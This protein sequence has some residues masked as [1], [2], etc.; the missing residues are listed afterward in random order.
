MAKLDLP[1]QKVGAKRIF[2]R[3][4]PG[5]HGYYLR[6]GFVPA[7]APPQNR[8]YIYG[9]H[10]QRSADVLSWLWPSTKQSHRPAPPQFLFFSCPRWARPHLPSSFLPVSAIHAYKVQERLCQQIADAICDAID[11]VGVG[12]VIRGKHMCMMMRGVEKTTSD[13]ITSCMMRCFRRDARTRAEFMNL[14][15][16]R[17]TF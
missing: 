1:A 17:S 5:V 9:C 6:M 11:P 14:I 7:A 13:T 16:N 2:L 3:P 10:L 12:V 8:R 15:S 4:L